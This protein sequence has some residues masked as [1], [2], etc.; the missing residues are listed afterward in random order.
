MG[1]VCGDRLWMRTSQGK[2]HIKQ[3]LKGDRSRALDHPPRDGDVALPSPGHTVWPYARRTAGQGSLPK[4][5]VSHFSGTQ[6]QTAWQLSFCLQPLLEVKLISLV[7]TSPGG[8]KWCGVGRTPHYNSRSNVSGACTRQGHTPVRQDVARAQDHRP[9]TK[10]KGQ[11]SL[12]I[13]LFFTTQT[14]TLLNGI[15]HYQ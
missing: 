13:R 10:G 11:T 1:M 2:R 15:C 12:W 5:S 3:S 6:S 14:Y 8:Q 9:E 4:L 7:A